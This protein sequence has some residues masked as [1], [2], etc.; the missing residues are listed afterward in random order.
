MFYK[1]LLYI[2]TFSLYSVVQFVREKSSEIKSRL[3]VLVPTNLI[4]GSFN[5]QITFD[6]SNSARRTEEKLE[7]AC[8]NTKYK[9]MLTKSGPRRKNCSIRKLLATSSYVGQYPSIVKEIEEEVYEHFQGFRIMRIKIDSLAANK[10]VPQ[11]DIDKKLFWDKD[12]YYFEFCYKV[13]TDKNA[14]DRNVT[15]LENLCQSYHQFHLHLLHHTADEE[16]SH[17]M[18]R[19]RLHNVGRL[20]ACESS[21]RLVEYLTKSNFP[22]LEVDHQFIVYDRY[23]EIDNERK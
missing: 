8:Q 10:G 9:I 5:V 14:K 4:H 17:Y 11:T 6:C 18:V 3:D 12:T 13:S 20:N 16:Q 15:R 22:P 23:I 1:F 2:Y 19:M 21:N 7:K